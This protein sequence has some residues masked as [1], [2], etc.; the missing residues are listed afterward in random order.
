MTRLLKRIHLYGEL[1]M[2]S[3]TLFSLP[4]ALIAILWA[5][6]GKLDGG[7]LFWILVALIAGRNGAN[8]FN[9]WVDRDIDAANPR[10]SQRHLPRKLIKSNEAL[11]LSIVLFMVFE[12]AAYQ[13]NTLC[14][15]LSPIALFLF[16]TYSYT[17][18]FTWACHLILGITCAGAPVGAWV[19]MTGELTL[20]P[21]ML[22]SVVILWVSGFDIIYGT[23]DIEFDREQHLFSIPARF[24][25]KGALKIAQGL[26][27]IMMLGL[28]SLY[29]I[30]DLGNFYLVGLTVATILLALEHYSVEP[31]NKNKMNLAA[32]H[33]NQL[34]S[35]SLLIFT[36]LDYFV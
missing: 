26:H 1:V 6:Q 19:A 21:M 24:G 10:T 5:S 13:L 18:R 34:I 7:T 11:G 16:I 31:Q 35:M 8:A 9:R 2:F 22:G 28:L 4:F 33:L 36:Y 20:V 27:L 12:I 15:L 32:Y 14:L 30:M 25:L 3:H 29:F 17:K 23:Q